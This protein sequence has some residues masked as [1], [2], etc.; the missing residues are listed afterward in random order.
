M[1]A[2]AEH[3]DQIVPILKTATPGGL[4][5][6]A[7]ALSAEDEP[8]AHPFAADL[9]VLYAFNLPDRLQYVTQRELNAAGM[10][11][12]QLHA[13]AVE[14]LPRHFQEITLK[15]LGEGMFGVTCGGVLEASLLL[16]EPLWDKLLPHL[17]GVPLAAVP[18]RDLLFVIG[19][20]QPQALKRM[21]QA[22][23]VELQHAVL[24]TSRLVFWREGGRWDRCRL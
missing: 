12:A 13:K 6:D 18:A 3:L 4:L 20:K 2:L 14:N 11:A 24:E 17:P 22:A 9:V 1:S 23:K 21:Q 5:G 16:L 7:F 15:D 8:V 10:T 19:S